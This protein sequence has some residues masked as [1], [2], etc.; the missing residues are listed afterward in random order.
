[1]S[2]IPV[3]SSLSL[4]FC[5]LLLVGVDGKEGNRRDVYVVYM[6]AIPS[7]A[8]ENTL[9]ENHIQLLSSILPRFDL[10]I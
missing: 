7:Q 10:F 2:G 5:L 9:K 4:L 8:S 6:G 1:M 3:I